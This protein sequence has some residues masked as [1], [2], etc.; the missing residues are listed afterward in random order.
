MAD[1]MDTPEFADEAAA[2]EPVLTEL[3]QA[4]AE[5]EKLRDQLLRTHAEMENSRKRQQRERDEERKY[6]VLPIV[7]DLLPAFDN[8]QRAVTAGEAERADDPLLSGVKMVLKQVEEILARYKIEPIVA[9]GQP[10]DPHY[11]E[12]LQQVP[13]PDVPPMTVVR[14]L[15]RGFKLHDRVVRPSKVMVSGP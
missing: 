6:A 4:I 3:E 7:R 9:E 10:F 15:E 11:H 8:L 12:A 13:S 5:R 14:D 1:E 2:A